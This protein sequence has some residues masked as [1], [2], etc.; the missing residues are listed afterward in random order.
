MIHGWVLRLHDARGEV[1]G[2]DFLGPYVV[3]PRHRDIIAKP[4]V[5]SLVTGISAGFPEPAQ[6]AVLHHSGMP[7]PVFVRAVLHP[8]AVDACGHASAG[9]H[10]YAVCHAGRYRIFALLHAACAS[11][12]AGVLYSG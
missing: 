4:H 3:E 9:C 2:K 12:R 6:C 8:K 7:V 1:V 10:G 5:R 11:D